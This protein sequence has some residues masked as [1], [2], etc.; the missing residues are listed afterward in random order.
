MEPE[1]KPETITP[2]PKQ[3][4]N[5]KRLL[6]ITLVVVVVAC[7]T[8]LA[9][10]YFMNKQ[11][12]DNKTANRVQVSSLQK[13][14]D[15]LK[16]TGTVDVTSKTASTQNT[17]LT[18]DQIFQEVSTQF[19]LKRSSIVNFTIY[20]QDKVEYSY[21]KS[22]V[23]FFSGYAY[24]QSGKWNSVVVGQAVQGC[25]L[26]SSVPEQYKPV[27]MI[28]KNNVVTADAHTAYLNSAEDSIN[29]ISASAVKYI[30]S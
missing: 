5:Y 29:Y 30:G 3:K 6:L 13:Q 22:E 20:G 28:E 26:Y 11:V 1:F 8:G 24:K 18:N 4:I 10:W 9:T 25:S 7:A 15:D 19:G 12:D 23:E 2:E 27:C 14:I 21:N 16:K 17:S